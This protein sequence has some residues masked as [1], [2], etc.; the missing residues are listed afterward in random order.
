MT[1]EPVA[2]GYFGL[3]GDINKRFDR[4]IGVNF[5]KVRIENLVGIPVDVPHIRLKFQVFEPLLDFRG[6]GAGFE[7]T[8]DC[9]TADEIK[10]LG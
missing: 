10:Q 1:S 6:G 2:G 5:F 4:Q 7:F 8:F 3:R 9:D